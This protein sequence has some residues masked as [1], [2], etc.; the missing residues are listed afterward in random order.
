V[1]LDC[2]WS[3]GTP[4]VTGHPDV[5]CPASVSRDAPFCGGACGYVACPETPGGTGVFGPSGGSRSC[6]GVSDQ[7]GYGLCVWSDWRC[8]SEW[9]RAR[10]DLIEDWF[11]QCSDAYR[12]Q[13]CACMV[14]EPASADGVE[15]GSFVLAS[16][17]TAYAAAHPGTVRCRDAQWNELR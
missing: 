3:D 6:L 4:V 13:P 7:R 1:P 15:R 16:A 14:L 11:D 10:P 9:Q 8:T 12:G 17:C 2:V 5:P